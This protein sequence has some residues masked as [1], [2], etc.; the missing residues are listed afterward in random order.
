MKLQL[1]E[2]VIARQ[3]LQRHSINDLISAADRLAKDL[4]ENANLINDDSEFDDDTQA[5]DAVGDFL[6]FLLPS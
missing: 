6:E 1:D 3:I 5:A 2:S 4:R